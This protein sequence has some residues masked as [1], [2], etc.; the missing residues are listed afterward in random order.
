MREYFIFR[1]Y[2]SADVMRTI[3][4][5]FVCMTHREMIKHYR[6]LKQQHFGVAVYQH[7]SV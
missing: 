3:Y 4:E 7:I 1:Y 6:E 5:E 2:D